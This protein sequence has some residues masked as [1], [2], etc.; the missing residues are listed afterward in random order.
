MLFGLH[1]V[2]AD[3]WVVEIRHVVVTRRQY[4][5]LI[6][7]KLLGNT[8]CTKSTNTQLLSFATR[9]AFSR[10]DSPL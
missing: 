10:K 2:V 4:Y 9:E 7:L 8:S 6:Q 3:H 5:A 1:L